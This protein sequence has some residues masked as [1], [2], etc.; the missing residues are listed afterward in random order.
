MILMSLNALLNAA[1]DRPVCADGPL[2][3]RMR[4]F[5]QRVATLAAHYSTMQESRY[6]LCLADPYDFTCALFALLVSGK[7]PVIPANASAGH[8]A[9]LSLADTFDIVID[10]LEAGTTESPA[11]ATFTMP[12]DASFVMYTSGTSGTPK[13]V[14]KS[15]GEVDAEV[16]VLEAKWGERLDQSLVLGTVPHHHLYGLVFR[17]L[18]PLAAGRPFDRT[19]CTE[20]SGLKARIDVHGACAIVASPAQFARWP[21][22]ASFDALSF[23]CVFCGG[24]ALASS[25]AA[26]YAQ[27]SG[28]SPIEIYGS[29]E[30]GALA[31]RRQDE[32][33]AWDALPD[34]QASQGEDG[35]L[36]VAA[37][38]FACDT[39]GHYGTND[40]VRFDADGRFHLVGRLD[41][42]VKLDGKRLSLSEIETCLGQHPFVRQAAAVKLAATDMRARERLGVVVELSKSGARAWQGMGRHA[43]SLLLSR[44][45]AE[46]VAEVPRRWRF[47]ASLPFDER[48][49]LPAA[50]LARE[51]LAD[52]YSPD[53][54]AEIVNGDTVEYDLQIP[55]NLVHFSGHFPGMP[56]LPGVVQVDWAIGFAT[57]RVRHAREVASIERL[58]FLAP[59]RPRALLCLR[60]EHDAARSRV[61]FDYRMND[62]SCASG[63]IVYRSDDA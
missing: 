54:F 28:M 62:R 3:I 12:R 52:A 41:R 50:V 14:H 30:T 43:M 26:R 7:L 63:V 5:R 60:L 31:W 22:L 47:R 17:V 15:L 57:R 20:P 42:I 13:A 46:H 19:T 27:S 25:A 45:L 16:R 8:L 39:N 48:G 35:Q 18:W 24:S 51:F 21:E 9:G 49:K 61:R 32:S 36:L 33:E 11:D 1:A 23:T 29:T 10:H 40:A 44:H 2:L 58:K 55:A 34:V 4:Q 59:V 6:A 38:R 37:T 53:V 56:I